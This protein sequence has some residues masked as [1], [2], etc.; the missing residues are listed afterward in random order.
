MQWE[1]PSQE[2]TS[3]LVNNMEPFGAQ[4]KTMFGS[5]CY[6]MNGNMFTGVHRNHIFLRLSEQ[7]REGV[8][9]LFKDTTHFEPVEGRPMREYMNLSPL[10]YRDDAQFKLWIARSM[11]YVGS[12][13]PKTTK[14]KKVKK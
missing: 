9:E 14:V 7:D 10:L 12:L 4:K 6:F 8:K 3:L 2:L 11:K 5:T 13:P 1:K